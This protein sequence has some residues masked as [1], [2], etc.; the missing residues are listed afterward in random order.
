[1]RIGIEMMAVQLSDCRERGIHRYSSQLVSHLLAQDQRN[2]YVLYYYEGLPR[3]TIPWSPNLTIRILRRSTSMQNP[4][5]YHLEE[6]ASTNPDGLD[7]LLMTCPFT[8]VVGYSIPPRPFNHLKLA[9][10]AYDLIPVIY[11]EQYQGLMNGLYRETMDRLRQYDLFLAISEATRRDFARLLRIA[12]DR[13]VNIQGATDFAPA[14][15]I[16]GSSSDGLELLPPLGVTKPFVFTVG[17]GMEWRKN[18]RGVLQAFAALPAALRD[19]H[20]LVVAGKIRKED[21]QPM[22]DLAVE[23]GMA[24]QVVLTGYVSDDCLRALYRHCAA[25]VFPSLYEGF[26]LPILEAMRC[27]AP[28]IAGDNSSQ[29]EVVGDAGLMADVRDA[30]QLAAQ[31]ARVLSAGAL[32]RTLRERGPVQARKFCWEQTAATALAAL[33]RTARTARTDTNGM[34]IP[35]GKPRIAFFAPLPPQSSAVADYAVGLLAE[36]KHYYTIDLYHDPGFVPHVSLASSEFGCH[37]CRLFDRRARL[38][39]YRSIL[40]HVG[41]A[42]HHGFVHETL[43]KHSGIVTLHDCPLA[44]LQ[45]RYTAA[46]IV[47]DSFPSEVIINAPLDTART[48]E[49]DHHIQRKRNGARLAALYIELIE[50]TATQRIDPARPGSSGNVLGGVFEESVAGRA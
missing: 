26:G 9:T 15:R 24:A 35:S 38:L 28:V 18:Y 23:A 36:L 41:D 37:D 20:Q 33:E 10:L 16:T 13:I 19:A 1:M 49:T 25:F 32:A 7:L 8:N 40:Y 43:R 4:I 30:G 14:E 2:H 46:V 21:I 50:K 22:W 12:P 17:A 44:D 29:P 47:R 45:G 31:L 42:W 6:I 3:G 11:Q 27:G 5:L 39:Q 34:P 48:L